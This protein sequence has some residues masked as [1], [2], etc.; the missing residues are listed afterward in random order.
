MKQIKIKKR[1]HLNTIR[2]KWKKILENK[3]KLKQIKKFKIL[4]MKTKNRM[5]KLIKKKYKV[6]Q[7][8][9]P[10]CSKKY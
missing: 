10:K 9:N 5:N 7:I 1:N 3:N 6:N 8:Y 4:K 2:Q